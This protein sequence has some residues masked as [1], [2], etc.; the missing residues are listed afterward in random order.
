MRAESLAPRIET[1][2]LLLRAH[3]LS[4]YDDCAS[5]W[6]DHLVTR[7]IGGSPATLQE[8]WFRLLRYAG[9][10]SLVGY[11][12]WVI[13]EKQ[14]GRFAGEVGFSDS[15]RDIKP[16]LD[17]MPESGWALMPWAHG[18][19]FAKE[20]LAAALH[21]GDAEFKQQMTCCIISPDNLPSLRVA[22][23]NGYVEFAR[24]AYKGS[25]IVVFKR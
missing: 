9:H 4:D 20:A 7:F 14:S 12:Y 3:R 1:E 6:S 5:M 17:G 15:R 16:P 19:G 8:T 18:K 10:W 24:T 2:R 21:W 25:P 11:G 22:E 23:K 13:E